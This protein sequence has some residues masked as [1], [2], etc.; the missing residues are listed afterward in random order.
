MSFTA[1][2][3]ESHTITIKTAKG[4]EGTGGILGSRCTGAEDQRGEN[5]FPGMQN[6]APSQISFR[7]Q[8]SRENF[9]DDKEIKLLPRDKLT[10]LKNADTCRLLIS[11]AEAVRSVN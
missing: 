7:Q 9:P 6:C 2:L 10:C 8:C 1:S 3:A 11:S 4:E 5:S